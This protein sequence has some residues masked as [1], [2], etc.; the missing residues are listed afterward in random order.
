M[1]KNIN[2]YLYAL[3]PG[4]IVFHAI[5]GIMT[6]IAFA[7]DSGGGYCC[8]FCVTSGGNDD[9]GEAGWN[10][11]IF[12]AIIDIVVVVVCA[13]YYIVIQNSILRQ[14]T[15]IDNRVLDSDLPNIV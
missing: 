15:Q 9:C 7:M 6:I 11:L 13:F 5:V 14:K 10:I 2:F 8:C 1:A 4:N 12:F 3:I